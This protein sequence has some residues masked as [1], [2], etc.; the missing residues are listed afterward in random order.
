[1]TIDKNVRYYRKPT[2]KLR[3]ITTEL[4]LSQLLVALSYRTWF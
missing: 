1:M 2:E 3:G 4:L